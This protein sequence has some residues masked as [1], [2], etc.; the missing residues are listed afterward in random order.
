M[1][2]ADINYHANAISILAA[3]FPPYQNQFCWSKTL[4]NNVY[5]MIKTKTAFC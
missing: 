4:E 3:S 5:D 1:N 2:Q